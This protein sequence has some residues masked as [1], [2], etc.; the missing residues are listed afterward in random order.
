MKHFNAIA[1]ATLVAAIALTLGMSTYAQ[2]SADASA[3]ATGE[4][5]FRQM[6]EHILEDRQAHFEEMEAHRAEVDAAIK[7]NDYEAW[8]QAVSTGPMGAQMAEAIS[9]D[10][11]PRFVEAHKLMQSAHDQMEQAH[12][13]MEELGA[14]QFGKMGGHGRRAFLNKQS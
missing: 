11:F 6:H 1:G 3:N 14:P 4:Y 12:T 10:E 8:K 7:A 9:A 13:I 5:T 2:E